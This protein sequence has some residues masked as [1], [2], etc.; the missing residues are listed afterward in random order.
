MKFNILMPAYNAATDIEKAINSVIS[1]SY[2]DFLLIVVND[3]S[4]DN[5]EEILNSFADNEKVKVINQQNTGI[6]GA[7]KKAFEEL[8]GD[9][10]MF[11][12]SDDAME[13][14]ALEEIS[15]CIE[16]TNADIVQFGIS[17][18]SESWEYKRSLI[19]PEKEIVSNEN[20]L[21][22][23]FNGLNN[24]TNRPNLGIR[25]YKSELLNNF[26]FP[27]IASLGI[28][29]ILNLFGM[30]KCNKIAFMP[31]A[32]YLCQQRGNSVSRIKPSS[33]KVSGVLASYRE[34]EKI[35]LENHSSFA[36]LLYLKFIRFYISHLNIIKKLP[37]Y[38]TD[39]QDFKRYVKTVKDSS[40]IK[41]GFKL[42]LRISLLLIFPF[43]SFVLSKY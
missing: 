26:I 34:M 40:R 12:D 7:Y 41:L 43:L 19:F 22:D 42:N 13:K 18:F 32:Y 3:G 8:D 5:T 36:D 33:K 28:D 4:Q 29:E 35:L 31:K 24:G 16:K 23:Y 37:S 25:A 21:L 39:K 38:K 27:P 30:T 1:Q 6:A 11:L 20:I 10:I 9:Y 17:Y 14:N 2:E 15:E